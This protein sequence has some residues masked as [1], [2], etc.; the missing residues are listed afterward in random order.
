MRT[1]SAVLAVGFLLTYGK[2]QLQIVPTTTLADETANNTSAA[3]AYSLTSN[4]N[5]HPGNVS[6]QAV[7]DLLY[8]G[9]TTPVY[10][11]L[12]GWFG[13]TNHMN[14]GYVSND[15]A[16][17]HR[18]VKDAI[19]RG[20]SG[21]I[22]DWY[23]PT[24]DSRTD[25]TAALLRSEDELH[26]GFT[27]AVQEDVGALWNCYNRVGCD[28]TGQL[29]SDL[30]YAYYR[31]EVSP[32]YLR[33]NGRPV[34]PLFDV[35]TIPDINWSQ[36]RAS[37][38]GEPVL[39]DRYRTDYNPFLQWF[40]DGAFSW[41]VVDAGNP[42]DW[43][44]AYLWYFYTTG[45]SS[46]KYTLGAA[47]KG[48]ND[49][50]AAWTLNRVVSQQCGAVWVNTLKQTGNSYSSG[51]QL[52][53]LQ[54]DTWNDYEEGTEVEAG[55]E[56]CLGVNASISG[57]ALAFSPVGGGSEASTVD[58]Y[59]IFV[60][61]D[62]QNL[63]RL[64]DLGVGARSLDLGS[65]ALA[66]GTYY[67]YVKMQS[68]P[69]I[70]NKM[71]GAVTYVVVVPN[72]VTI[73]SPL[74]DSS[75]HSPVHVTASATATNSPVKAMQVY[76]DGAKVFE[77]LDSSTIDTY[78]AAAEGWHQIAVQA[79]DA[80]Y[81]Y[82]NSNTSV[83][84]LAAVNRVTIAS[85]ANNSSSGS[86]VHVVASATAIN[87]PI[88]VMQIYEDGTKVYEVQNA[89]SIDA[90]VSASTGRAHQIVVQAY[91]ANYQYFNAAVNVTVH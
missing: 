87:L 80:N 3:S 26:P 57:T 21:F 14:V 32:A 15:P 52:E 63:M 81:N 58:H 41:P 73:T 42:Y 51:L 10:A 37:V 78:L 85:P 28:V 2:A 71:S 43:G 16:Q 64:T 50:L 69:G 22:L 53:A 59:T 23:G 90:Y 62:G 13:G 86:P 75:T 36:V 77:L 40:Y 47:Y 49:T 17:M 5:A 60:S 38:V 12:Q 31:Y 65:Y 1:L 66:P 84:V 70:L 76:L 74:T 11:Q 25:N 89:N 18:Q 4:G 68:R 9:A 29:I 46:G 55:V 39:I 56:N 54:I 91:D 48:F 79:Y 34:V 33:H 24:V 67:L 8:P 83:D 6:K 30:N 27:F 44:Q 35:N 88:R 82:F 45:K 61:A 7:Q 20:L 72:V 19:S